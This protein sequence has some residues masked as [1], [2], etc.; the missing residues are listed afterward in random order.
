MKEL[1]KINAP[2]IIKVVPG[3]CFFWYPDIDE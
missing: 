2:D 1:E 3:P